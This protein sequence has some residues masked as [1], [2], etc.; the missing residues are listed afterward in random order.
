[1]PGL[2]LCLIQG[3]LLFFNADH[4]QRPPER[5]R[6]RAAAGHPVVRA[7]RQRHRADRQHRRRDARRGRGRLR[8]ARHPLRHRRAARRT[9]GAARTRR[10]ARRRSA[11]RWSSRTSRTRCAPFAARGRR[12]AESDKGRVGGTDEQE[13]GQGDR[14]GAE[15]REEDRRIRSSPR[16]R[17]RR[18]GR[19][20]TAPTRMSSPACRSRSRTCRPGSRRPGARIVIIF[21]GRDAAGKGGVIKRLTERVSPRVFRVVGAAGADRA[22]E[23]ADVHPALP[24]APA[25]GRRGRDLR[26]QLVQPP[27]RRARH[28]LL[29]RGAGAPLPGA[30]ST[31]RGGVSSRAA[32]SS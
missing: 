31:L 25:G 29:H 19:R 11:R 26:P 14:E 3:S 30:R 10:R 21:E 1:M 6:R 5:D 9:E 17:P 8:R 32:S 7:R 27:R 22:R 23:V 16:P 12:C 28:G 13:D 18:P 4:V 2:A 15:A 20:A 24:R